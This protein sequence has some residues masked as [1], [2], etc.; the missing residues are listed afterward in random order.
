MVPRM[1]IERTPDERFAGLSGGPYE[2]RYATVGVDPPA[3]ML[4]DAVLGL[5]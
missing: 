5:G 1:R 2:P 4:V 3:S